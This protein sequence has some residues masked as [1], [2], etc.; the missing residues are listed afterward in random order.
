MDGPGS[1][2]MEHLIRRTGWMRSLARSLVSDPA[3]ADDL[4]QQ[5]NLAALRKTAVKR[6]EAWLHRVLQSAPDG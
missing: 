5:A 6:P 3:L 4:V 2:T 1:P